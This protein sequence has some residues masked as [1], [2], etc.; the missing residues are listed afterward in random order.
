MEGEFQVTNE[1]KYSRWLC[2]CDRLIYLCHQ[3]KSDYGWNIIFPDTPSTEHGEAFPTGRETGSE[4]PTMANGNL[5]HSEPLQE[6][7]VRFI[8]KGCSMQEKAYASE[9]VS[10]TRFLTKEKLERHKA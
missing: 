5:I 10:S 4:L 2:C 8:M 7:L 9:T 1:N 3:G 6:F